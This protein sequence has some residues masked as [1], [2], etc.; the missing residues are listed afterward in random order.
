MMR[1]DQAII[2]ATLEKV[3]DRRGDPTDDVYA[4][5]FAAHPDLE[6]LFIMDRDGGVRASMMQQVLE[7]ILDQIGEQRI[8]PQII[9]AAR[10]HHEGYGVPADRFDTFFVAV[11]DTFRAI[12]GDD[13]SPE[14]D[15]AWERMLTAFAAAR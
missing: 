15:G 6:R 12:A 3:A 14:M 10:M 2:L 7:C 9:S 4:K 11:R 8:A 1:A 13:W 5:L